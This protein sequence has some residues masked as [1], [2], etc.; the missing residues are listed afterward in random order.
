MGKIKEGRESD[1]DGNRDREIKCIHIYK[2]TTYR[3]RCTDTQRYGAEKSE[4]QRKTQGTTFMVK[5]S[6]QVVLQIQLF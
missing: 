1:I 5:H 2:G 4:R 6:Y 3:T